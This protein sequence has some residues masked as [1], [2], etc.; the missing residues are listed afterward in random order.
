MDFLEHCVVGMNFSASAFIKFVWVFF[1]AIFHALTAS[2]RALALVLQIISFFSGYCVL[3]SCFLLYV[4]GTKTHFGMAY[5]FL[6]TVYT[7]SSFILTKAV[8]YSMC[9]MANVAFSGY[10]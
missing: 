2:S 4:L 6:K 9:N 8:V 3:I 5:T 7:V 1:P 10:L